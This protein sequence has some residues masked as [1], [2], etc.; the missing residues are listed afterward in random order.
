MY[1][2]PFLGGGGVTGDGPPR[3]LC[4]A[5]SEGVPQKALQIRRAVSQKLCESE[6]RVPQK[7]STNPKAGAPRGAANPKAVPQKGACKSEGVP[8]RLRKS[9]GGG[10]SGPL[11]Q[12]PLAVLRVTAD[13]RCLQRQPFEPLDTNA[14]E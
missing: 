12:M 6:R 8:R 5:T 7:A 11:L 2:P 9:E 1:P 3:S 14:E 13:A 4:S 10:P